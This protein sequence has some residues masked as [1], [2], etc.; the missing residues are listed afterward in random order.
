MLYTK[1]KNN[2]ARTPARDRLVRDPPLPAVTGAGDV[3]GSVCVGQEPLPCPPLGTPYPEEA[4]SKRRVTGGGRELQ[5]TAHAWGRLSRRLPYG[6]SVSRAAAALGCPPRGWPRARCPPGGLR[7][8][9]LGSHRHR[10]LS[11]I[12]RDG[13]GGR[14]T[15]IKNAVMFA[16]GLGL[17]KPLNNNRFPS[18]HAGG[19]WWGYSFLKDPSEKP[20][21]AS[22]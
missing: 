15:S 5:C 10:N 3:L 9:G 16:C 12:R 22:R 1:K 17:Q 8:D 13:G 18:L 7:R 2:H 6:N 4:E 14:D 21:P 11:K 19:V 20:C